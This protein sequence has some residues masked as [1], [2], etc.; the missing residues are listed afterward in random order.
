VGNY[1]TF[2]INFGFRKWDTYVC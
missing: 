1:N 2:D